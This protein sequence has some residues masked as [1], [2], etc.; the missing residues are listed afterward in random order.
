MFIKISDIIATIF[1]MMLGIPL[2]FL[3][4]AILSISVSVPIAI[5]TVI[6]LS[7]VFYYFTKWFLR[8]VFIMFISVIPGILYGVPRYF[9]DALDELPPHCNVIYMFLYPCYR[10]VVGLIMGPIDYYN[11]MR[12]KLCHLKK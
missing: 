11:Y 12:L 9:C 10:G 1:F 5:G 3:G 6:G 4:L 7:I 8:D 2:I